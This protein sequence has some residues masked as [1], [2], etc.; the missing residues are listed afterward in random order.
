MGLL[1]QLSGTPQSPAYWGMTADAGSWL[2][3]ARQ[4]LSDAWQASPAVATGN[5]FAGLTAVAVG[6]VTGNDALVNA[7]IE[8]MSENRQSNV[9][10][11][12]MLGTMGR[13]GG[14]GGLVP[15]LGPK[16]IDPLHHNA[17]VTIRDAQGNIISHERVVSGNMTPTEQALGFPKNTLA[18]HTEARA[19]R[20]TP[21][22]A[23]Q[24]MTITGQLP[25]CPSC[26]GA[27]N[28]AAQESGATIKYQWRQDGRTQVW[29]TLP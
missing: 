20:N 14:S 26:K 23:G 17:N 1:A 11:L 18:S 6:K 29:Q 8:G 13:G 15:R 16:G 10:A 19:V 25:P 7:G 9:D 5:A 2:S 27:M 3:N 21:L 28:R 12:L 24:S 4:P 22:E